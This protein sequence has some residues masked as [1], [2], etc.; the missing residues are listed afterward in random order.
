MINID[1][2]Q[3]FKRTVHSLGG[4]YSSILN[5][6]RDIRQKLDNIFTLGMCSSILI[7][8]GLAKIPQHCLIPHFNLYNHGPIYVV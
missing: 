8:V 4:I 2:W 1:W 3:K 5:L 6:P 7:L